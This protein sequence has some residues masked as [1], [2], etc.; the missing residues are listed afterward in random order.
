[1]VSLFVDYSQWNVIL[2]LLGY[3]LF[4][5]IN[6]LNEGIYHRLTN[7]NFW[8]EYY[9]YVTLLSSLNYKLYEVRE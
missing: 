2:K 9:Q 4:S 5:L 1:M 3:L 7:V 8:N 6:D